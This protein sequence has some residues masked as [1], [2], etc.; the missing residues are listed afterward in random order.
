MNPSG[1]SNENIL[2]RV[3]QLFMQDLKFKKGF[4]FDHINIIKDYEKFK[5]DVPTARQTT[6]RQ[7]VNYDSSHSDNPTSESPMSIFPRLSSH[8]HNFND[9]GISATS[10]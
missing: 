2:H 3:K 5:D 4:K 6:R 1:A 10:S 8:S 7:T 9:D